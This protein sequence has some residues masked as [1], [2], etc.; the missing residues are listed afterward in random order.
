MGK[1]GT[2]SYKKP[3]PVPASSPPATPDNADVQRVKQEE[4]KRAK[5][6]TGWQS[7][8]LSGLGDDP[9]GGDKLLGG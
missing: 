9:N 5:N 2:P 8:L 1:G 3:D 6:A 7:T 4:K